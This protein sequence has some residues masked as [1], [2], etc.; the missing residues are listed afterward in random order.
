MLQENESKKIAGFSIVE[1]LMAMAIG[2]IVLAGLVVV[3]VSQKKAYDVQAQ[4]AEMHQ[5]ARATLDIISQDIAGAG[6]DPTKY[7]VV[8]VPVALSHKVQLRA[9][10]NGNGNTDD[11]FEDV[12]YELAGTVIYRTIPGESPVAFAENVHSLNFQYFD[13]GGIETANIDEIRK[14]RIELT[15]RTSRPDPSFS[16]NGGY[17]ERTL[18]SEVIPRNLSLNIT[19]LPIS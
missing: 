8:A 6:Y 9:D 12:T 14:I 15:M 19:V 11:A 13:A 1:M 17:R 2:M 16:A 18:S 10:L 3:F 5:N 7:G 4:V